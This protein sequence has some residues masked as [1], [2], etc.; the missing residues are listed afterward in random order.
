M[1]VW[2]LTKKENLR[3]Y[4]ARRFKEEAEFLGIKLRHVCEEDFEIVEPSDY[5]DKIWRK[6]RYERV[7]DVLITRVSGMGYF[8]SALVRLCQRMGV[9]VKNSANSIELAEDKLRTVQVLTAR[10]LPIPKSILAKF[11]VDTD[12]IADQLGFPMVMK[13]VFGG[14]GEGVLMFENMRQ[15]KDVITVLQKSTEGKTNLIFQKFVESS[16]GRDI[17]VVVVADQAI[18]AVMRKGAEGNFKSNVH[19]GG[20]AHCYEMTDKIAKIAVDASQALGLSISG[21]DLLFDGDSFVI[22]EVNSSPSF[23]DSF[24]EATKVNVPR[25]ILEHAKT[26]L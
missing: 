2:V 6:G 11:P 17:R 20:T 19:G 14:K 15:F 5:P 13:T 7:P 22:G 12:Y 23:E 10:H 24:E 25:L 8:A 21:V 4:Q 3:S 9:K 26:L 18:V 1:R 16:F